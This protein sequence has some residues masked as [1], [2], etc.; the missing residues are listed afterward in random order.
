MYLN[1]ALLAVFALLYALVSGRV[2]R[3]RLSGPIVFVLAGLLLGPVSSHLALRLTVDDLRVLA[4][5]TLAVVLFSDAANADL[6]RIRHSRYLPRRLL[7]VGL[8]LTVI[9]GFFA[10][11]ALFPGLGPVE[12]ALIATIL[13]PT[14]AALGKPVVTNPS[15]PPD[16][17]EAL[18]FESGLND[19]ICVPLVL[20]LLEVAAGTEAHRPFL[21]ILATV[22]EEI[23]I[24]LL[25]GLALAIPAA[26]LVRRALARA[27]I[28]ATWTG[29][30]AIALAVACFALAQHLGGSGFIAAFTGG[31]VFGARLRGVVSAVDAGGDVSSPV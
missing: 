3:S 13:A 12:V 26:A 15:V 16:T 28:G 4:E 23:G 14:D 21:H 6:A 10:G 11:L 1:A 31:L 24:G 20:L 27:W 29:L 9:L 7:L 8:P 22:I 5:I 2:E 18:N 25:A 19:G 30:P 17:R